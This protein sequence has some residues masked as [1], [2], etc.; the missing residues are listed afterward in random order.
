MDQ[1]KFRVSALREIDIFKDLDQEVLEMLAHKVRIRYYEPKS[2]ILVIC[3]GVITYI[4][5]K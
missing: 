3:L 1:I 5:R 4:E 2:I